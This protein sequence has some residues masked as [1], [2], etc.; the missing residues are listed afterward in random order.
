MS[1]LNL[2]ETQKILGVSY[3]TAL[4]FAKQYGRLEESGH[5]RGKWFIPAHV[6]RNELAAQISDIQGRLDLIPNGS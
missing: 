3:P 1:E 4:Q 5:P 2:K 6:V